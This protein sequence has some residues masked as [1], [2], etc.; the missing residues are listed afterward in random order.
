MLSL[1]RNIRFMR[2]QIKF[3][4][5]TTELISSMIFQIDTAEMCRAIVSTE[6]ESIHI[7]FTKFG[8]TIII[9]IIRVTIAIA[10]IQGNTVR[11][12]FCNQGDVTTHILF[13]R[14][15]IHARKHAR[16]LKRITD[17]IFSN[18]IDSTTYCIRSEQ[19]RTTTTHYLHT[20]YHIHRNLFQ[21]IYPAKGTDDRTAIY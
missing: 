10:F 21:S 16:Y 19:S 3:I 5:T 12:I 4:T 17:R 18:D 6:T 15:S 1:L 9:T 14:F 11:I 2:L 20:L 7:Q 13:P 8:E